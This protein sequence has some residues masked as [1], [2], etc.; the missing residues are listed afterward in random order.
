V[1]RWLDYEAQPGCT[2]A[3]TAYGALATLVLRMPATQLD[4]A[5]DAVRDATHGRAQFPEAEDEAHG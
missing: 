1:R 4:A 3:D 2:L 5:R